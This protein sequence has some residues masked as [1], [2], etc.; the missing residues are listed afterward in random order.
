MVKLALTGNMSTGGISVDRTFDAHPDNVEIAEEAARM[1]GPTSPASTSSAPDIAGTCP[2]D[3]AAPSSRSTRHQIGWH[4][5]TRLRPSS[6]PSRWSTCS[7]HPAR[8][9]V[10][11]VAVTGTTG[12]DDCR[13]A[14]AHIFRGW[15]ARSTTST[16]RLADGR[17]AP[18][19]SRPMRPGLKSARMVL[20]EPACRLRCDGGRPRRHPPRGAFGYDRNDVAVVTNVAPDHLGLGGIDTL[21]QLAQVKAVIVEAVPRDGSVEALRRPAGPPDAPALQ[22]RRHLVPAGVP[23]HRQPRVHRAAP[24]PRWRPWSSSRLNAAT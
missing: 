21:Q 18:S 12:I 20:P 17:E 15:A 9:R 5:T 13:V 11:I 14:I 3:P 16:I 2:R 8:R 23:R 10:L 7:S 4:R 19:S 6:S 22:R 24:P 1:V